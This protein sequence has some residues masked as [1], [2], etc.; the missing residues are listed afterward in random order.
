M[1]PKSRGRKPKKMLAAD[2]E[3]QEILDALTG[4]VA[5]EVQSA[6]SP[7]L[8]VAAAVGAA[9]HTGTSRRHGPGPAAKGGEPTALQ[10]RV[11]IAGA[12]PPIWRRLVLP[13]SMTLDELHLTLQL[14][15]EW[16]DSHLHA[17]RPDRRDGRGRRERNLEDEAKIR[18]GELLTGAGDRLE[19]EYEFGD[20]WVHQIVVEKRVADGRTVRCLGGRRAGPVEDCGGGFSYTDLVEAWGHPEH[21]A[22]D[23]AAELLEGDPA[24]FD[25]EMVDDRFRRVPVS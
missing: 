23:E 22:Y 11:D 20:S 3:R 1:S 8:G 7:E 18:V 6:L 14:A 2:A 12:R 15:F 4:P 17:F 24:S 16:T 19:Y 21:P 25:R 13:A 9:R 10:V 5:E